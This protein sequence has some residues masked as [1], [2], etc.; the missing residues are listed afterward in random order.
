MAIVLNPITLPASKMLATMTSLIGDVRLEENLRPSNL[1]NDLVDGTR[2]GN[3][4]YG[5]GIVFPFKVDVQPVKALSKTS[6]AFTITE[7]NV[8]E[9][10]IQIDEYN[11]IP[12]SISE[13]LV[14]DSLLKGELIAK[15]MDYL[16]TLLED[17]EQFYLYD[18]MNNLIQSWTPGQATQTITITLLD[19]TGMTG[20][21]LTKTEQYNSNQIAK[22]I[23]KTLNNMKI[24]NSKYTDIATYTSV[25]DGN[26]YPVVSCLKDDDVQIVFND[27][28]MTNFI[29][30]SMAS[31]YHGE[32]VGEMIP[33]NKLILLP[34][35]S[36]TL[37]NQNTICWLSDKK[38]FAF[39]DF[40][41]AVFGILDP[42]TL[43]QNTFLHFAYGC[44]IFS[45]AP[46]VKFV[47][48]YI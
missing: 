6:S 12:I 21:T 48:N 3:V 18:V 1:V 8:E 32:K 37:A 44:G 34:E 23:R 4:E 43:Y 39:A 24:K 47:A 38:K 25:N 31:L 11:F 5:K 26:T 7:P 14:K 9:E 27:K 20:D 10:T 29:A 40:Y 45:Y 35:D 41:K 42:S 17:T 36:M 30:D 15:F 33:N 16:M 13:T 46:G 22:T 19:T 28:Y 2:I